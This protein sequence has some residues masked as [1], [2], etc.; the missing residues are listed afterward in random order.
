MGRHHHQNQHQ[1]RQQA[2]AGRRQ[3]PERGDG[4]AGCTAA[5]TAAVVL[6]QSNAK[7]CTDCMRTGFHC[8]TSAAARERSGRR[9]LPCSSVAF[10][11]HAQPSV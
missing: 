4:T 1:R 8:A 5:L 11:R 9:W 6:L 2:V 7:R 3:V 10:V